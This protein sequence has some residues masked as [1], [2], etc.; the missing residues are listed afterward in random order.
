MLTAPDSS[1]AF[2]RAGV[3][4]AF[5]QSWA[6]GYTRAAAWGPGVWDTT[7]PGVT[8][9]APSVDTTVV[10]NGANSTDDIRAYSN[11]LADLTLTG[12]VVSIRSARTGTANFT[13]RTA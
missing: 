13:R 4:D 2:A 7:G 6:G 10:N 8:S 1:I 5:L 11:Y 9:T 3:D 12:D